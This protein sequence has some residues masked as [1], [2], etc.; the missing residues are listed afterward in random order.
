M[1]QYILDQHC[2]RSKWLDA[3]RHYWSTDA[4]RSSHQNPEETTGEGKYK[5]SVQEG[6]QNTQAANEKGQWYSADE[7]ALASILNYRYQYWSVRPLYFCSLIT[8]KCYSTW[9]L[10]IK[11]LLLSLWKSDQQMERST[12]KV[13]PDVIPVHA[14]MKTK[15]RRRRRVLGDWTMQVLKQNCKMQGSL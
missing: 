9:K 14:A 8:Q 10:L 12:P 7:D 2:K 5:N 6:Q 11:Y 4:S 3:A 13:F 1:L 15:G